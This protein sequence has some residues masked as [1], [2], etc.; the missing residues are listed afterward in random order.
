[1]CAH[2]TGFLSF[3]LPPAVIALTS[4]DAVIQNPGGDLAYGAAEEGRAP[5]PGTPGTPGP[6]ERDTAP[7]LGH[8]APMHQPMHVELG[9]GAYPHHAGAS[10][11]SYP[12]VQPQAYTS[13]YPPAQTYPQYSAP[14]PK[15]GGK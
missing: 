7:L 2:R 11:S 3:F 6:Y 13:F 12:P 14:D 15:S 8:P 5:G 10:S 1:M 4:P 9:T